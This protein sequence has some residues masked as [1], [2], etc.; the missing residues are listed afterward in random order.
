MESAENSDVASVAAMRFLAFA[1]LA[2]MVALSLFTLGSHSD[3]CPCIKNHS[4]E[5]V[6]SFLKSNGSCD[7]QFGI[8]CGTHNIS[9]ACAVHLLGTNHATELECSPSQSGE[10]PWCNASWCYVDQT[11]CSMDFDFGVLGAYSY[12]TCGNLRQGSDKYYQKSMASLLRNDILRVL[13]PENGLKGGYLGNTECQDQEYRQ[14]QKCKGRIADFWARSLDKLKAVEIDHKIIG[15]VENG[16]SQYFIDSKLE[17]AFEEYKARIPKHWLGE[18]TT[19]FDLCAFATGTGYVDLCSGSFALTHRRQAM[20]FMIELYTSPIFMISQSKCD[21]F[22]SSDV[23]SLRTFWFWWV[24]VFSPEA[25]GVFVGVVFLFI[26]AMK[27]LDKFLDSLEQQD[28]QHLREHEPEEQGDGQSAMKKFGKCFCCLTR[29]I[30]DVLFG[31]FEAFAFQSKTSHKRDSNEPRR[32]RPSH[33]LRLGLG[34]FIGLSMA[35]YGANIT[36]NMVKKKEV[37]GEVGSLEAAKLLSSEIK[38]CTHSVLEEAMRLRQDDNDNIVLIYNDTWEKVRKNLE[39]KKCTAALL[40]EE[41]WT[42]FRSRGKHEKL[43]EFYKEPTPEFYVPAGAVVSKRAY[44]T[45]ETFRFDPNET[46]F[47]ADKSGVPDVCSPNSAD[48]RC[49]EIKDG[50]PWYMLPGLSMVAVLCGVCTLL[51]ICHQSN[52]GQDDEKEEEKDQENKKKEMN[53]KLQRIQGDISR[54][55]QR[56]DPPQAEVG[57]EVPDV[58]DEELGNLPGTAA[59]SSDTPGA[60][61]VCLDTP[62]PRIGLPGTPR[63]KSPVPTQSSCAPTKPR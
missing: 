9:A 44:R 26:V 21:F 11:N 23:Y 46:A 61:G 60:A 18:P 19:N 13:H 62:G 38:V 33:I 20:T 36:A 54:I 57:G 48:K 34:F 37:K 25:W 5:E 49:A 12:A 30:T 41:A 22:A 42:T 24:F 4:D 53:A 51:G 56:F 10:S 58:K 35:V 47:F 39:D 40:D 52:G 16:I 8:D 50:V 29:E 55:L 1:A 6:V 45:L 59:S 28:E 27:C 43:C 31:V 32:S 7:V 15:K 63:N 2:P 3:R 14:N 17:E